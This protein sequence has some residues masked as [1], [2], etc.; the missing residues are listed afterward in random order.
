VGTQSK[1]T[2]YF[3]EWMI[4][5]LVCSVTYLESVFGYW[6]SDNKL[7]N[8]INGDLNKQVEMN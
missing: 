2:N 5:R 7:G 8:E 3:G 1:Q 4:G 6:K